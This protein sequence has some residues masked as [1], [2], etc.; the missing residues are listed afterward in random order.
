MLEFPADS[1]FIQENSLLSYSLASLGA[2]GQDDVS[3]ADSDLV[4]LGVVQGPAS[5]RQVIL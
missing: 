4:V 2:V 3:E 1:E 5:H